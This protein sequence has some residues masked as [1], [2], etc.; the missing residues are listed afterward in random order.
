M[1][2]VVEHS[3]SMTAEHDKHDTTYTIQHDEYDVIYDI[4]LQVSKTPPSVLRFLL[5]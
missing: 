3:H 5:L 4:M 2:G 1:V